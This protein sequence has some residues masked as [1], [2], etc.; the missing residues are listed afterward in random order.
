MGEA[1]Y[2]PV[3]GIWTDSPKICIVDLFPSLS[4]QD[5]DQKMVSAANA[6]NRWLRDNEVPKIQVHWVNRLDEENPV[7]HIGFFRI[8]R[9]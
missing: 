6:M 4:V 8:S 7:G 3:S 9:S 1:I 5:A 2:V